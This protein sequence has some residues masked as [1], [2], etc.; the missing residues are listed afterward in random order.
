MAP[1]DRQDGRLRRSAMPF[2]SSHRLVAGPA[3]VR[4]RRDEAIA[5]AGDGGNEARVPVVVLELDPQ[6][7]DVAIHD[8]ALGDEVRAPDGIEDLVPGDDPATPAGPEGQQA[9]PT[10]PEA[11]TP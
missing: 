4:E 6:A 9:L 7:P 5:L 8:V 2:P 10:P 3:Q 1:R 11:A